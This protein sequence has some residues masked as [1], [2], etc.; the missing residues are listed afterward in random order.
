MTSL[1]DANNK[2]GAAEGAGATH[3]GLY[4]QLRRVGQSVR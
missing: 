4:V 2:T 1:F 3:M